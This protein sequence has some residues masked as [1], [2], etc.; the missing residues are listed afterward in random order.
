MRLPV[1]LLIASCAASASDARFNGRWDITSDTHAA[2]LE[3][4]GAGT[5]KP[6]GRYVSA[7]DGDMNV[8]EHIAIRKGELEFG[9]PSRKLEFTARLVGGK[10]EGMKPAKWTG[11]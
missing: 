10:L 4:T 5:A 3:I 8:I 2:W 9:W 1:I 7:F 11:V 6:A